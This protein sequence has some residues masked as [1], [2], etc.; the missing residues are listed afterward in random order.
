[1]EKNEKFLNL[2]VAICS[3]NRG[4]G[5]NGQLPWPKI[6]EDM[7]DFLQLT[8]EKN[9]ENVELKN[10]VI[11]GRKTYESIP[12]QFR[13]LKNRIN[14]VISTNFNEKKK[15]TNKNEI[16]ALENGVL[17]FIG[18]FE[19]AIFLAKNLKNGNKVFIAGGES[20]Y[21]LALSEKYIPFVSNVYINEIQQEFPCDNFF[22]V[23]PSIWLKLSPR[24]VII[25][26]KTKIEINRFVFHF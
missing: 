12:P 1:M 5:F 3:K 10:I 25:D 16:E 8:C 9:M 23:L 7:K 17:F 21:K 13:P 26:E 4:I 15:T 19:N 2:I 24:G 20:I 11:M 18:N 22:P 14:I 6:S